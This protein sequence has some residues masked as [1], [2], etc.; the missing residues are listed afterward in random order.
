MTET[1]LHSLLALLDENV[2]LFLKIRAQAEQLHPQG[3]C[4]GALRNLLR[5]L[6]QTGP[7]TVPSL[8]R[9]RCVKRQPVQTLINQLLSQQLIES[10][11][12]PA[13]KRSPLYR[14]TEQGLKF[15]QQIQQ[16]EQD[17]LLP[18][19]LNIPA[20]ELNTCR[21]MLNQ[22]RQ[23]LDPLTDLPNSTGSKPSSDPLN[24]P[25]SAPDSR[26]R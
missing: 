17:L 8:A 12:N 18:L 4:S 23:I 6:Q 11:D 7:Q 5:H 24:Q 13:H 16:R 15:L 22:I 14:L 26:V 20:Q 10:H 2:A 25:D 21:Q 3:P 1:Q 19:E 9:Q